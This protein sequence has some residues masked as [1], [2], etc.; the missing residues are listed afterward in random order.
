[1]K[2]TC[3]AEQPLD[4]HDIVL[5]GVGVG[6]QKTD[7]EI[8]N[9]FYSDDN[10]HFDLDFSCGFQISIDERG[11]AFERCVRR[12]NHDHD[13][14]ENL[15]QNKKTM[16]LEWRGSYTDT[17]ADTDYEIFRIPFGPKTVSY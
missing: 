11:I 8:R 13:D 12:P 3:N 2:F 4:I 16:L 14:T 6:D 5:S 10:Y 1:M 15:Y 7:L 17:T 9:F